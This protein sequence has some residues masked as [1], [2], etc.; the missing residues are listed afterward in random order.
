MFIILALVVPED[1]V[2]D[3]PE[4]N[5]DEDKESPEIMEEVAKEDDDMSDLPPADPVPDWRAT[6]KPPIPVRCCLGTIV[7]V[8]EYSWAWILK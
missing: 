5:P 6:F 1:I 4:D 8:E 3:T 2:D 7:A